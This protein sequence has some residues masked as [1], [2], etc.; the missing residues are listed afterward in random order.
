M[1]HLGEPLTED[2]FEEI[3]KDWDDD[4]DDQLS[5]DEFKNMMSFK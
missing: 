4:G 1:A 2:E 5:Y 3:M